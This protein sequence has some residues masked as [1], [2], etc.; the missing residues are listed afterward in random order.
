[1]GLNNVML[2]GQR[3][4][5]TTAIVGA[6]GTTVALPSVSIVAENVETGTL[7]ANLTCTAA[8]SGITYTVKWQVCDDDS[9]WVDCVAMNSAANVTLTTGTAAALSRC[10]D[11]PSCVYGK[12][13]ARLALVTGVQTAGAGDQ[14]AGSYNYRNS[15]N[16]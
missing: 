16:Y 14:Y 11:A 9:T 7:S 1:M 3:S 8:T 15:A 10:F 12:Q 5:A 4:L 2:Q 6:S 13:Y